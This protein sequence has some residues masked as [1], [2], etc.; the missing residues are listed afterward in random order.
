MYKLIALFAVLIAIGVFFIARGGGSTDMEATPS[1]DLTLYTTTGGYITQPHEVNDLDESITFSYDEGSQI[2]LRAVA[3]SGYSFLSW[4]GDTSTVAD[5]TATETTVIMDGDY[6]ITANFFVTDSSNVLTISSSVGGHVEIPGESAFSYDPG[7]VV[8]LL[9]VPDTDY[10]F[11]SWTGDVNTVVDTAATDTSITMDANYSITANFGATYTLTVNSTQG[12]SVTDPGEGSSFTYGDGSVVNL[13]A[14]AD[15]DYL[16]VGWT[17]DIERVSGPLSTDT[18]ITISGNYSITA[19]F[20]KWKVRYD[21][22][23]GDDDQVSAMV[24]DSEGNIYITGKSKD[25]EGNWDYV[26]VKYDGDLAQ[27]WVKTYD[28][29]GGDTDKAADIVLDSNDNVY[30]TGYSEG[31]STNYD[32]ATIAYDSDGNQLWIS[33][34]ETNDSDKAA[35]IAIDSDGNVYVTGRSKSGSGDVFTTVKYNASNGNELWSETYDGGN[36]FTKAYAISIDSSNNVYVTGESRGPSFT[37]DYATVKYDSD[38]NELWVARYD[39]AAS[40]SD[41][42]RDIAVDADGNVYITG[43]S[44]GSTTELDYAT[45]KY[46]S[47][48]NQQW[49]VRY[50]GSGSKEDSAQA[51]VLDGNYLYVTGSSCITDDDYDYATVKYRASDGNEEWVALYDGGANGSDGAETII[52]DG[53][54]YVYITGSSEGSDGSN[55]YVTIKYDSDGNEDWV[56]IF[57]GPEGDDFAR[58]IVIDNDGNIYVTGYSEGATTMDD[59][60][61]LRITQ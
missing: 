22:G 12:G 30:V 49:V 34:Y 9:A 39:G 21:S 14:V 51:I 10:T 6:S 7:T 41:V 56:E 35:A 2:D 59:F 58:D 26:T 57:T 5:V 55:D 20:V 16:F 52:V 31:S 48:G 43:S 50:N 45:I 27:V 28:G 1:F 25:G 24:T 29:T 44:E 13:S 4:S 33:R 54:G 17:G 61:T 53:D 36:G 38:G 15:E 19:N 42:A 40:G 23:E 47:S 8:D 46:N 37:S 3:V 32:Y 11:V 18:T 60:L